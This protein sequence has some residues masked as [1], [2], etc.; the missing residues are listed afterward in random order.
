MRGFIA[1]RNIVKAWLLLLGDLR[2]ARARRLGDRR[3]PAALDLRLR[4][5]AARRRRVLDVRPRRA[6]HGRARASCR[7]PRR[8]SCTR[9]SSGSPRAPACSKP[10]LYLI[11][12]GLPLALATGR[13]PAYS[14]LAFS[15]GCLSACPPAELEGVIA[16]ELAHVQ[17][18]DVALQ[19]AVV[20]L[21]ASMIELSRVG[22]FL[23]RA[24]LFVL[25]AGRG[26]LRAPAPL[27]EARVRGGPRARPSSASRRTGSPTRSLRLEQAAEL[28]EFEASPGD[29]AALDV[30]SVP[31]GGPRRALRHASEGRRAR[32][33][34]ARA[35]SGVAREDPHRSG[36]RIAADEFAAR[37]EALAARLAER[38][39]AGCVLFDP[40]YVLYYT[41]FAFI[42]TERPIAFVLAADARGGMLVPR[43]EVEHAQANA[44]G[45][46]RSPTTTS[47]R[48]S[49]HPMDGARASCSTRSACAAGSAPTTTAT[50]GSSATA[51]RRSRELTA[52][53][54]RGRRRSSRSRW[55]SRATPSSRCSAR[56]RKWASLA[57]ALLQQYTRPGVTETEVDA[58]ASTEATTRCSPSSAPLYRGQSQW[59]AGRLGRLPRPDRARRRDPARARRTTSSSRRAT[60]S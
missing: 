10:K 16:H 43:L 6:R 25:G 18:R 8:R 49:A 46:A 32:A 15:S 14:A 40:H 1:F 60:C 2:R 55:R 19:T 23:Q 13:G 56:A 33:P 45:R 38:G 7:S 12:D 44:G 51:G 30:Q 3:R 27:A 31:R 50:R 53:R 9:R 21:A 37:R 24:L 28:V 26:R 47:S 59:Y 4:G 35:R 5:A 22:G 48:A 11:P 57:H 52:R 42:P 58:R 17:H 54:R 34:A 36:M 29:R 39:L 20:V 41:G